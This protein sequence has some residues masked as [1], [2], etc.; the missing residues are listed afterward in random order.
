MMVNNDAVNLFIVNV[1]NFCID[2]HGKILQSS[3][4]TKMTNGSVAR[5]SG[6]T[7]TAWCVIGVG[8]VHGHMVVKAIWTQ[9]FLWKCSCPSPKDVDEATFILFYLPYQNWNSFSYQS[10]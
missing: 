4:T 5:R 3:A 6:K 8:G 7:V 10:N 1:A 9:W 2:Q